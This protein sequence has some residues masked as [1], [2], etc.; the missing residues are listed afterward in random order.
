MPL[1]NA[2]NWPS[3][4][5]SEI[6][7]EI[8]IDFWLGEFN[9]TLNH[10][11]VCSY[12]LLS[13][14]TIKKYKFDF[15]ILVGDRY[16]LL[17]AATICLLGNIRILHIEGGERSGS[18]DEGIRHAITKLAHLHATSNNEAENYVKSLGENYRCFLS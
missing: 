7:K 4:I 11:E 1:G 14:S 17:S 5:V 2:T 8:G 6:K 16:E 12:I 10:Y 9:D 13:G 3:D 15:A 18:I